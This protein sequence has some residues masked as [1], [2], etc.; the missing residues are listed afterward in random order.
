MTAD[1]CPQGPAQWLP[2]QPFPFHPGSHHSWGLSLQEPRWWQFLIQPPDSESDPTSLSSKQ[3]RGECQSCLNI[4]VSRVPRPTLFMGWAPG[5]I[6]NSRGRTGEVVWKG[7]SGGC[8]CRHL[9]E[10]SWQELPGLLGREGRKTRGR[11]GVG[12]PGDT[13]T[14]RGAACLYSVCS[15]GLFQTAGPA[16]YQAVV[17]NTLPVA[18]C[19]RG[20][21]LLSVMGLRH[22]QPEEKGLGA[23]RALGSQ[24]T[25]VPYSPAFWGTPQLLFASLAWLLALL[26]WLYHSTPISSPQ[27]QGMSA[28]GSGDDTLPHTGNVRI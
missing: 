21:T 9:V 26:P 5:L 17:V 14:S 2:G 23:A 24:G 19:P 10:S 4:W 20:G 3:S 12:E 11:K 25:R 8:G 16:P 7:L 18:P 1:C 22:P 27:V 6:R 28:L 15:H 13:L